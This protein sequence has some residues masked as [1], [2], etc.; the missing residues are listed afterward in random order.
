VVHG[1]IVTR[2]DLHDLLRVH[3]ASGAWV[4]VLASPTGSHRQDNG[5]LEPA[6]VYIV[7]REA[8]DYIPTNGYQDIKESLLPTLYALG[9]GAIMQ[10]AKAGAVRRVMDTSSYVSVCRWVVK[11]IT[12]KPH[13]KN[14]Y[15][16]IGDAC[17]HKTAHVSPTARLIGPV[18]I[19]EGCTVEQEAMIIGPSIIGAG[20]LVGPRAVISRSILWSGCRIG[21]NVI[22]DDTVLTDNAVIK[23]GLVIRNTVCTNSHPQRPAPETDQE[24]LVPQVDATPEAWGSLSAVR[25]AGKAVKARAFSA[26]EA[27]LIASRRPA[28]ATRSS[29]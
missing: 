5:D 25:P 27:R 20:C 9:K 3:E 16:C 28:P 1:T 6:G 14:G 2:F 4:T 17:V 23:H 19:E 8:L 10:V 21:A 22:L 11:G 24:S 15:T 12:S 29:R 26:S 7:S 18:V 13:L